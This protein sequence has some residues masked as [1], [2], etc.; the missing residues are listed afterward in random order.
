MAAICVALVIGTFAVFGGLRSSGFVLMD[1]DDYVTENTHVQKGLSGDSVAWAFTTTHAANWHPL[2][3]LSH[4]LDVQ[5]F[6]LDAGKHHLTSLLLHAVNAVL[7]FLI[8]MRMTG[9]LWRSAFVAALFALH[10]LHV[11][12]VA[13]IAERKD[14]LS[15]LFWLL[16]LIAWLAYVKSSKT[17]PY[18]LTVLFY[19]LGLMAKP[20]VVTLPF[21]LL[22]LDYWP[23]KRLILPLRGHTAELKKLL[24]E[25]APLFAMAAASCVV[26]V[27]VQ[28][29]GGAVKTTVEFP[30]GQRVANA[31]LAYVTYLG[32]TIWPSSLA[33][34]YPHPRAGLLAVSALLAFLVLACATVLMLRLRKS[35]PYLPFGWLW[36][37]GTL[38]PVIGL[39][40]VGEQAMADRYT[41]IPLIGIFVA[42]AWGLAGIGGKSRTLRYAVAVAAVASLA[43][44]SVPAHIQAGYWAGNEALFTHALAVTTDNWTA[45]N[46][47]GNALARKGINKDAIT[48]YEQA[49]RIKPRDPKILSNLGIV[50][51]REN[52]F[53]EAIEC[54]QKAIEINPDFAE[55][56]NNLGVAL[57]YADQNAEAIEHYRQAL[58]IQP[59][60]AKTLDN[61][62]LAFEATNRLPEAIE[63]F[64]KAV[65][66]NPDFSG[67]HFHLGTALAREHRFVEAQEHLQQAL[68]IEPGFEEA[69]AGLQ[70]VRKAL[71][72]A[73]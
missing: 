71:G 62:G 23:L 53:S 18:A 10:P 8:F 69:R 7:L 3:W 42:V 6:G 72:L 21:T 4:M 11:E 32:K 57:A 38:V 50:L 65:H 12:S 67:A 39:I 46:N 63:H 43:G 14:V 45:H 40:Q 58:R 36:Y 64:Q 31:A 48:H 66:L 22:L 54:L 59:D 25:K 27:I 1:D 37:L 47:L 2:T 26:T 52:R 70:A 17:V 9:A 60:S 68:R 41:Y 19:A 49:L 28:H 20:M 33:V 73:P 13:W 24:W 55:A 35:A 61:L 5:L 30:L 15:T 16:T 29:S 51:I 44:L 34:F 56:Q